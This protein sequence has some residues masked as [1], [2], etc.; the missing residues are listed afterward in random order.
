ML[1]ILDLKNG[2]MA[3][4]LQILYFLGHMVNKIRLRST[5]IKIIILGLLIIL[6]NMTNSTF[7][8]VDI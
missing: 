1:N 8:N 3:I 5:N 4:K 6:L 2:V 7:I